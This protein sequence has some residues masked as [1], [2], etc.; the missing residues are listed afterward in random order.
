MKTPICAL[1]N[2]VEVEMENGEPTSSFCNGCY[3][4]VLVFRCHEM[5]IFEDDMITFG[6]NY[7]T[8]PIQVLN[9]FDSQWED[10]SG[11]DYV[12]EMKEEQKRFPHLEKYK[13]T[14]DYKNWEVDK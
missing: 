2:K 6:Y 5:W 13:D 1:C 8:V 7:Q 10:C 12:E 9:P 14:R 11:G 4:D 3:F